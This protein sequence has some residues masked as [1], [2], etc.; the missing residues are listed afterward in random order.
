MNTSNLTCCDI[1]SDNFVDASDT[2]IIEHLLYRYHDRHRQQLS[3]LIP[4]AKRVE[5]VHGW[6]AECPAGLTSQLETMQRELEEHMRKE[7]EILFPMITHGMRLVAR[8]PVKLMRQ[9]HDDHVQALKVIEKL[10]NNITL[11]DGACNTW[12]NLYCGLE[13]FRK[14]LIDHIYLENNILFNRIDGH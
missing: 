5:L 10:T 7:E 9:Q 11:P 13:T 2:E 4:M 12:R 8:Q 6:Q 3:E 14:D 1:S